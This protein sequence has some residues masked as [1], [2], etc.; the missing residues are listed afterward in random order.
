MFFVFL[1]GFAGLLTILSFV[2]TI[3]F[4]FLGALIS[5]LIASFFYHNVVSAF[6]QMGN[7]NGRR[8]P[9]PFMKQWKE[10]VKF[11]ACWLAFFL[12]VA[13]ISR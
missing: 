13:W 9:T 6:K 7:P 10:V 2:L 12:I 8:P 4:S 1:L 5:C 11:G 3:Q